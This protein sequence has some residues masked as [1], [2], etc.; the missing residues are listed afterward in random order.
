MI[1]ETLGI[2]N[3]LDGLDVRL[4]SE[5][6]YIICTTLITSNRNNLPRAFQPSSKHH[7]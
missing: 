7:L 5:L 1:Q 3:G 2:P 4:E 6:L